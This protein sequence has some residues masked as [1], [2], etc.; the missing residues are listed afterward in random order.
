[1]HAKCLFFIAFLFGSGGPLLASECG[2]PA[3]PIASIQGATPVS[4]LADQWVT[5]EGVMTLDARSA[6]GLR[7][8]YLQQTD[9]ETDGDPATSEALFVYTDNKTGQQGHRVRVSGR[10]KEFHELT[11]LTAVKALADCGPAPMPKAVELS[12][13]WPEGIDPEHLENMRVSYKGSLTVIDSYNLARYGELTLAPTLQWVPTQHLVP[14]PDAHARG[15]TQEKQR[16]ILDDASS[17]RNPRPVPYPPPALA[18]SNSVRAG[19]RITG[20]AGIIDYRFGAWRLQPTTTPVFESRKPRP[21]AP[22]KPEGSNLRVVTF[23]LG[24]YFNGDGQGKGFSGQRGASDITA[25]KRQTARFQDVVTSLEPDI[26]TVMEVENDGYG[27]DSALANLAEALGDDWAYL[28]TDQ[29]PGR[30]AI[31][32]AILY[33]PSQ[34]EPVGSTRLQASIDGGR[35][36]MAQMFQSPADAQTL[37]V[38]ASHLKSKS[39]R[40]A[41]GLNRAQKDGQGCYAKAR[42]QAAVALSDWLK[43]LSGPMPTAGTLVTG[44]LNSYARETPLKRLAEAGFTDLI[45]QRQGAESY[46]YRFRGRAGTLDYLLADDS[47]QSRIMAA[48]TWAI[49]ADEPRALSTDGALNSGAESPPDTTGPAPWRSSDHDPLVLDLGL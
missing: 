13:L 15:K 32:V 29:R 34:I 45:R 24:N 40:G 17:R 39:C 14:G 36:A 9:T 43:S 1:M 33:R 41:N 16:L 35:P 18:Y 4:P 3:T 11:E 42:E 2:S 30:D 27:P 12:V 31:K 19:D 46:S 25:L 8:F 5:V 10:V 47:L 21:P 48:Q 37:R 44:D 38:V 28:T 20:L 26:L 49:N 6:D 7:G 23:N 22:G